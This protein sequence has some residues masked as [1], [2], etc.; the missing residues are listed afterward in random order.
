MMKRS[1]AEMTTLAVDGA[2]LAYQ[3]IEA[4]AQ[5]SGKR[6]TRGPTL[7][8]GKI[9]GESKAARRMRRRAR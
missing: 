6:Q 8:R 3:K 2:G 1:L 5:L 4:D 9:A 7:R